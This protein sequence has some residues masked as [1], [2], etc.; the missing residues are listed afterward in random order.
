MQCARIGLILMSLGLAMPACA[1]LEPTSRMDGQ[2]VVRPATTTPANPIPSD[3]YLIRPGDM[4][5]VAVWK[6]E[7]LD[8]QLTVLPDGTFD[9]PLVGSV[10][11]AGLTTT[12]L[13][14]DIKARLAKMVPYASVNVTVIE[15]KGNVVSI[16]GQVARPGDVVMNRQMTVLQA[17]SQVGG[18]TTYADDD[19]IKILRQTSEGEIS[20]PFDYS[21]VSRGRSLETNVVL[22]PGDVIVVPSASL[23]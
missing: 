8:R 12:Q 6:E 22:Q 1:Q 13:Q 14:D 9:F 2:S 17:L 18:L 16:V 7:E 15:A 3:T 11:A 5:H 10:R 20:I 23:F 21:A 4:L 19:D